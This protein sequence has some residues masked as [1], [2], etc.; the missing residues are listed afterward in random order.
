MALTRFRGRNG[1][2]LAF[3]PDESSERRRHL[4]VGRPVYSSA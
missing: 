2:L 1:L 4:P 3:L